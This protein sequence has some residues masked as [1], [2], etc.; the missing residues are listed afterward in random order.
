VEIENSYYTEH[1]IIVHKYFHL[2]LFNYETGKA[3]TIEASLYFSYAL[4]PILRIPQ[5]CQK[6]T[7]LCFQGHYGWK[8]AT[9]NNVAVERFVARIAPMC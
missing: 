7:T 3:Q 2:M 8:T 6:V 1:G 4:S 9:C 5:K